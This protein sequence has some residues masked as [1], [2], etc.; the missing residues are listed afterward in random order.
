MKG[1]WNTLEIFSIS[2]YFRHFAFQLAD[3]THEAQSQQCSFSLN[4]K[5]YMIDWVGRAPNPHPNPL[6]GLLEVWLFLCG[7]AGNSVISTKASH[8]HGWEAGCSPI[9]KQDGPACQPDFVHYLLPQGKGK[10]MQ[11][12]WTF[13]HS[14]RAFECQNITFA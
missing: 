2:S 7:L 9:T 8:F 6:A 4:A 3:L 11:I 1:G 12:L 10:L 13:S 14:C 5:R